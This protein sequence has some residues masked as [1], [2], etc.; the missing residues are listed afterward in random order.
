[1]KENKFLQKLQEKN[2]KGFFNK[3]MGIRIFKTALAVS[4]SMF[5]ALQF[6]LRTPIMAGLATVVTMSTSVFDSFKSSINRMISTFLGFLIAAIFRQLGFSGFLPFFIGIII[7][8]NI[9]KSLKF[10]K[11]T[12]LAI[13]VFIIVM[14]HTPK[15]PLYMSV[16]Q[17]G[18]NRLFDTFIGLV[19]GVLVNSLIL[20]PNQQ[21]FIIRSY[22]KN[23]GDC[24]EALLQ[25]I[26]GEEV[27]ANK[28]IK[29]VHLLI[30]DLGDVKNDGPFSKTKGADLQVLSR[31]NLKF[32]S[33]AGSITQFVDTRVTP[34]ISE[35]NKKALNAY[36]GEDLAFVNAETC[37]VDLEN[38]YNYQLAHSIRLMEELKVHVDKL[39]EILNSPKK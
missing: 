32:Y 21:E 22:Q 29:D 19:V 17:Y 4:L 15:P 36:F 2:I 37:P 8:I 3:F 13:M 34:C 6:D 31:I 9:C 24:E 16:W 38:A 27:D 20:P 12:S 28:I 5:V 39:E 26:N 30:Q 7:I 33:L 1:M 23:L 11:A 35:E 14:L 18:L 25:S 10:P